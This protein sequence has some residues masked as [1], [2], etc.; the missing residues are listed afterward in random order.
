[1]QLQALELLTFRCAYKTVLN[2]SK[3]KMKKKT[4]VLRK[5]EEHTHTFIHSFTIHGCQNPPLLTLPPCGEEWAELKKKS[6]QASA[7]L[8]TD[9]YMP[10]LESGCLRAI[11]D[12]YIFLYFIDILY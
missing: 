6:P 3:Q 9:L 10:S 8:I 5:M 12:T 1:M 7:Y 2:Q 11:F 4:A